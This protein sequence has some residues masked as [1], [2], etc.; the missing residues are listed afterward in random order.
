MELNP[1]LEEVHE[2][3]RLALSALEKV[4]S[5][6]KVMDLA[7]VLRASKQVITNE[8]TLYLAAIFLSCY[9]S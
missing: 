5:V 3:A 8:T 1:E 2:E 9:I 4:S 6:G 7:R